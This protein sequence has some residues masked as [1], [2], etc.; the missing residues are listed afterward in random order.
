MKLSDKEW[1][2]LEVLW[3]TDGCEL[4]EIVEM[5]KK[6]TAWSR[7]T[8][9]TYLTRMEAK[10]LVFIDKNMNPHIYKAALTKDECQK[11]ER[12]SFLRRVYKGSTSDMIAAFL[13]EETITKEEMQKL[14]NLLDNMEV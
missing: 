8:V 1:I 14:K 12:Q 11:N 7:N 9:H 13:K 6:D 2:V 10:G 3:G 5:L 4:G